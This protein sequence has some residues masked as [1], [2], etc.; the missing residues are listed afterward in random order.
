MRW[1]FE[2]YVGVP[3]GVE[4]ED[5]PGDSVGIGIDVDAVV[6]GFVFAC[7]R[8][9]GGSGCRQP[10]CGD[11]RRE[12]GCRGGAQLHRDR[13]TQ[14]DEAQ[15]DDGC[16]GAAGP[17]G[18]EYK[19]GDKRA[20]YGAGGCDGGQTTDDGSGFIEGVKADLGAL[21]MGVLLA[22]NE[23][24]DELAKSLLA[25]KEIFLVAFFLSIGFNG[26]P[27]LSAVAVA[28]VLVVLMV[29]KSLLFYRL[30]TFFKLR[31]RT[32]FLTSL[33]LSNYS[34]FGLIVGTVG[35]AGGL[36]D[37]EWLV[38][39]A[40]ALSLTFIIASFINNASHIYYARYEDTLCLL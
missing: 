5:A 23:K 9:R 14:P 32:S 18:H 38:I 34:E 27:S 29:A 6:R 7:C 10:G 21:I 19:A 8:S 39:I 30:L 40:I 25:F 12:K 35:V 3:Q 4:P 36:M 22:G 31:A 1:V 11:R 37:A 33:S 2:I 26:A 24:S 13:E 28:L 20:E 17:G 15:P 16:D